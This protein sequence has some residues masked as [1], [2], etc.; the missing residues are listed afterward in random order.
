M[1][2]TSE[3]QVFSQPSVIVRPSQRVITG[4]RTVRGC[5]S[6]GCLE[7]H[8]ALGWCQSHYDLY[9]RKGQIAPPRESKEGYRWCNRCST[10][11]LKEDFGLNKARSSGFD[12]YC[13]DCKSQ[14]EAAKRAA[15][16][17]DNDVGYLERQ[18]AYTKKRN[19]KIK[20]EAYD[21]YGH[22]CCC[23]G[24]SNKAFLEFDHISGDGALHRK[25]VNSSNILFQLRKD[26]WPQVMQTLCANCHRAKTRGIKCHA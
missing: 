4:N 3:N 8:R 20:N 19:E 22:T 10:M 5:D 7:R 1:V 2:S 25:I 26:G 17:R 13:K 23:C 12:P 9:E 14:T 11:K 6:P 16:K 24:E 21:A 15:A 18:R